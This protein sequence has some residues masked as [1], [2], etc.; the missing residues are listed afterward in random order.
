MGSHTV[1]EKVEEASLLLT[2]ADQCKEEVQQI[3]RP[4]RDWQVGSGVRMLLWAE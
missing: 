4:G 3:I 2:D 1:D